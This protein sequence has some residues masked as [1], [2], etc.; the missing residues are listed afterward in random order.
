MLGLFSIN[1][2]SY[3]YGRVGYDTNIVIKLANTGTA[4]WL[5]I[6]TLLQW[7]LLIFSTNI[8][9]VTSN[10]TQNCYISQ[11][12]LSDLTDTDCPSSGMSWRYG[13]VTCMSGRAHLTSLLRQSWKIFTIF[14]TS[15]NLGMVWKKTKQDELINH[16][17][18]PTGSFGVTRSRSKEICIPDMDTLSCIRGIFII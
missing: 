7:Q 9:T 11:T 14:L 3:C 18:C 15:S 10:Y 1:L 8:S 16:C 2:N 12:Y 13:D 4:S 5:P 17:V 6:L